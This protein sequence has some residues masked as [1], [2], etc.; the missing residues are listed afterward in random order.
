MRLRRL[1]A[2]AA[3]ARGRDIGHP[4]SMCSVP[5]SVAH[6]TYSR[7]D[8]THHRYIFPAGSLSDDLPPS[9]YTSLV[10]HASLPLHPDLCC[11]R[12]NGT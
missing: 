11:F 12:T 10:K 7:N 2:A 6:G 1:F 3:A 4:V 5:L 9:S 8:I